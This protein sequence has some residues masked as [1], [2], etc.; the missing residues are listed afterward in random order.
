MLTAIALGTTILVLTEYSAVQNKLNNIPN[1]Q[2]NKNTSQS[3]LHCMFRMAA[4]QLRFIC[5]F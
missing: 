3:T 2:Y 1:I 5:I 4:H